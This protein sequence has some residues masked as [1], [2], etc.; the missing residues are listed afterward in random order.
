MIPNFRVQTQLIFS[1]LQ[2]RGRSQDLEGQLAVIS[3]ECSALRGALERRSQEI[4][5]L[6]KE[7]DQKT[8]E[9]Q[10]LGKESLQL[11]AAVQK[12]GCMPKRDPSRLTWAKDRGSVRSLLPS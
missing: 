12:T 7:L 1:K 2:I 6:R 5:E 8:A 9:A 11:R 10:R 4:D 3:D